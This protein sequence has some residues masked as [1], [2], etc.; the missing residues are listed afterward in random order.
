MNQDKHYYEQLTVQQDVA[1]GGPAMAQEQRQP[2]G[3]QAIFSQHQPQPGFF[4]TENQQ[5]GMDEDDENQ[6][7]SPKIH[8]QPDQ[9]QH[10]ESYSKEEEDPYG[11]DFGRIKMD[12]FKQQCRN[13]LGVGPAV[14]EEPEPS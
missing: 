6:A 13:I 7:D 14:G 1:A 9:E 8:E 10:E 4:L 2:E 12:V 3:A 5:D 11:D